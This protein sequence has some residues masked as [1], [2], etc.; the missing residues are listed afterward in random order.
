MFK[1]SQLY[2]Y[3]PRDDDAAITR[4]GVINFLFRLPITVIN[5]S[6]QY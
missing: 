2:N 5:Y 1:Q 6:S 4:F 3:C